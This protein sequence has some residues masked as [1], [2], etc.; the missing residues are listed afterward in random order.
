VIHVRYTAREGGDLLK[1]ASIQ[2]LQSLINKGQTVGS[3]SL[4]SVRH[5]FPSEWA[6]F[7]S[8]TIGGPILTAELS[9]TLQPELYPFWSQGVIGSSSIRG[10][11]FYAE[12]L[13]GTSVVNVTDA[14]GNADRL[15]RNPLL[16]NLLSGAL[17][18]I[19]LPAAI[20]DAT[21]PPLRLLFD[22]NTMADLW[23]GITWG[24]GS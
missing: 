19:P 12:M 14:K 11:G 10:I 4:F 1:A 17:T 2:N 21:H 8:V 3:T 16:G 6:K 24:K 15:V 20:T 23:I 22:N 13:K 5:E 9:L 18:K 7:Q